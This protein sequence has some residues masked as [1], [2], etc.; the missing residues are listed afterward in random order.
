MKNSFN[1]LFFLQALCRKSSIN[2]SKNIY[3]TKKKCKEIVLLYS[4]KIDFINGNRSVYNKCLKIN[5]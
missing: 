2:N 5:G 4:T 3:L 1:Q